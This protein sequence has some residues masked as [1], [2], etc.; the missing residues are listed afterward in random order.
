[1]S[2]LI[3]LLAIGA[4]ALGISIPVRRARRLQA[5]RSE[6]LLAAPKMTPE[7]LT[8]W[9]RQIGFDVRV[10]PP[11]RK[12][13]PVG[14]LIASPMRSPCGACGQPTRHALYEKALAKDPDYL[15]DYCDRLECARFVRRVGSSEP[16]GWL[17]LRVHRRRDLA[18]ALIEVSAEIGELHARRRH[19]Q[20]R[21]ADAEEDYRRGTDAYVRGLGD[22][23]G[24]LTSDELTRRELNQRRYLKFVSHEIA[25]LRERLEE[26]DRELPPTFRGREAPPIPYTTANPRRIP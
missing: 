22:P 11:F 16:C 15:G 13:V 6:R 1:M 17:G 24:R 18:Q 26:L 14:A 9:L 4:M 25:H 8:E 10:E 3:A 21:L 7:S 19:L 12:D 5:A 23:F 2:V 20:E